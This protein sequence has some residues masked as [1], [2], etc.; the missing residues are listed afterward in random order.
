MCADKNGKEPNSVDRE[1]RTCNRAIVGTVAC[2][3]AFIFGQNLQLT[4]LL[5]TTVFIFVTHA[6]EKSG[7]GLTLKQFTLRI[8]S[9]ISQA[10]TEMAIGVNI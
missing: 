5:Q 7:V 2:V 1:I 10:V 8:C 3:V 9:W 4:H 6:L